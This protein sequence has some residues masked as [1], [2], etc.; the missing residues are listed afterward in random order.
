MGIIKGR[1]FESGSARCG[2][3]QSDA[4]FLVRLCLFYRPR[5]RGDNTF[6]SVRPSV[7]YHSQGRT[8]G[9]MTLIFGMGVDLDHG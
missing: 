7:H 2:L 5:S 3:L 9:P 6:G 1:Q 8:I 4:G